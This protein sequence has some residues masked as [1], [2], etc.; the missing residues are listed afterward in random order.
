MYAASCNPPAALSSSTQ[1][2]F[3]LLLLLIF[4]QLITLQIVNKTQ[5]P[6]SPTS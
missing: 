2:L 6:Y 5:S 4:F 3:M 1:S